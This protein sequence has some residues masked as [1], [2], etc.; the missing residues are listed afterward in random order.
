MTYARFHACFTI[1]WILAAAFL[2]STRWLEPHALRSLGLTLLIVYIFTIPWDNWAA[3]QGVWGFDPKRYT[4]RI[5]HLPIEEYAFFGLQTLMAVALIL[6]LEPHLPANGPR[7]GRPSI[8][9]AFLP[10]IAW[11]AFF[12]W[13]RRTLRTRPSATYAVHMFYWMLPVLAFQTAVA[14]D[15]LLAHWKLI[16]CVIF[17]LG[18]YLSAADYLAIRW[19]IWHFDSRKI[20]GHKIAGCLPW[21]EIAFFHLTTWLVANS[22]LLFRALAI[23]SN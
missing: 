19:K 23:E 12:P 16:T 2:L 15:I 3:K 14:P 10:F 6:L 4:L 21:E 20:T 18:V 11:P 13:M 17:G 9:W 1:P 7:I 8:I 5:G 22:F